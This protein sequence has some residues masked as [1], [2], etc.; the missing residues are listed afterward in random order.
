MADLLKL[1]KIIKKRSYHLDGLLYAILSYILMIKL[2]EGDQLSLFSKGVIYILG[3]IILV[4]GWFFLRR[5]PRFKQNEI[6]ILFAPHSKEEVREELDSLFNEVTSLLKQESLGHSFVFKKIPDNIVVNDNKTAE[7]LRIK[8]R[9]LLLVWGTYEKGK[10]GGEEASGFHG[11]GSI[12]FTYAVYNRN[13]SEETVEDVGK[14]IIDRWWSFRSSNDLIERNFLKKNIVD[15]SRFIIGVCLYTVGELEK[16]KIILSEI[17]RKPYGTWSGNA[18]NSIV[19]FLNTIKSKLSSID[20]FQANS[21]YKNKIFVNGKINLC[22]EELDKIIALTQASITN[23]PSLHA[24]LLQAIILFLKNEIIKSK[25]IL[26]K[27]KIRWKSDPN[28]YYSLAFLYAYTGDLTKSKTNYKRALKLTPIKNAVDFFHIVEFQEACL[29]NDSSRY[30]LHFTLGLL[31]YELVDSLAGISHFE[32][33]TEK[34]L[35]HNLEKE[36]KWIIEA[37]TYISTIKS[38]EMLIAE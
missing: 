34:C 36:K 6:G 17:I 12:S 11:D 13:L 1:L 16:S 4:G 14:C 28:I 24:Y 22:H 5:I 9:C 30:H 21:L 23:D 19:N 32:K 29:D 31:N 33:F 8:S 15:V 18:K 3:S 25:N 35:E 10:V 27:A 26:N 20:N 7:S 38:S 2:L 37:N